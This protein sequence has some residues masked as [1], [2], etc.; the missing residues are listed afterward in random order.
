LV[1]KQ[2][3]IISTLKAE[4]TI[5][6]SHRISRLRERL[7]SSRVDGILISGL[8]NV[9]YFSGFTGYYGAILLTHYQAVLLTD[10]THYA[11]ALQEISHLKVRCLTAGLMQEIAQLAMRMRVKA[12]GFDPEVI[13]YGDYRWIKRINSKLKMIS[14]PGIFWRMREVKD[15]D[16]LKKIAT[17]AKLAD[18][19]FENILSSIKPGVT[20]RYIARQLDMEMRELGADFGAFDTIVLSGKRTMFPHARPSDNK[21]EKNDLVLIDFGATVDGYCSDCTRTLIVGHA[22]TRQNK[23]YQ[24]VLGAFDAALSSVC[25]G[26]RAKVLDQHGRDVIERA[27]Y[28]S[29]FQFPIGHGVG[30]DVHEAPVL[31]RENTRIL[32]AGM[33]FSLEPG[34]YIPD[35]GG[36]RIEELVQVT[37]SGANILTGSARSQLLELN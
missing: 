25:P 3:W 8:S 16:E 34:V 30:L 9:R 27:G 22:N 33:V 4:V 26:V 24:L 7:T 29:F 23:I 12:L 6:Y 36:I 20:E 37:T 5:K 17:C 13:S 28:G 21:L 35:W 14:L 32:E 31:D 10:Y 18:T 1:Y 15:R 11:Q 2:F 19:A